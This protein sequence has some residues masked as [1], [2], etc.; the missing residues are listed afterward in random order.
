MLAAKQL[1][2]SDKQVCTH[3][4]LAHPANCGCHT[5]TSAI[6]VLC[7]QLRLLLMHACMLTQVLLTLPL[8]Q[9]NV[10]LSNYDI[11]QRM[12]PILILTIYHPVPAV[13]TRTNR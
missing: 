1:G 2:F 10:L 7:K 11:T 5:Y 13:H 12:M 9:L 8:L 6:C 3:V 4:T